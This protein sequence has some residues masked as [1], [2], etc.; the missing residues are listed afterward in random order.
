M[1]FPGSAGHGFSKLL[2]NKPFVHLLSNHLDMC[3]MELLDTSVLIIDI[4]GDSLVAQVLFEKHSTIL[5]CLLFLSFAHLSIELFS[6]AFELTLNT[7]QL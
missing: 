5:Y 3:S 7:S 1:I 2:Q 4:S 6:Q